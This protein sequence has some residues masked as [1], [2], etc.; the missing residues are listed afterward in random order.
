M[1]GS[2]APVFEIEF[3]MFSKAVAYGVG[4]KLNAS[5]FTV[6]GGL[7]LPCQKVEFTSLFLKHLDHDESGPTVKYL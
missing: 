6:T 5:V 1:N 3:G 7:S 2:R 4:C